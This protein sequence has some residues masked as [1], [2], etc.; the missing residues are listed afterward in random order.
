M[1]SM[2]TCGDVGGLLWLFMD[3]GGHGGLSLSLVGVVGCC[4][5]WW[6]VIVGL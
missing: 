2:S 3:A 1:C 4:W 5:H 6:S